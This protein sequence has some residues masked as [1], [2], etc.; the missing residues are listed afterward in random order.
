MLLSKV[1]DEVY[2]KHISNEHFPENCRNMFQNVAQIFEFLSGNMKN[3]KAIDISETGVFKMI[4][5]IM[6][7]G[8]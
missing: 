1:D 2:T 4:E 7:P 3:D 8:R 6:L 5:V